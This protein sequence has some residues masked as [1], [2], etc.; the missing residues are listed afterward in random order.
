MLPSSEARDG[1]RML[2]SRSW[3]QGGQGWHLDTGPWTWSQDPAGWWGVDSGIE[4]GSSP[5]LSSKQTFISVSIG[6]TFQVAEE[7]FGDLVSRDGAKQPK[8]APRQAEAQQS[9]RKPRPQKARMS[10]KWQV[11]HFTSPEG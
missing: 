11:M 9:W 3:D 8:N 5:P 2:P 4:S 1:L 7:S 6:R 10:G